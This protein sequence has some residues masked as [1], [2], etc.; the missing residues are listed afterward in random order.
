MEG[1]LEKQKQALET[2]KR[3]ESDHLNLTRQLVAKEEFIS[4]SS[5]ANSKSF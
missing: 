1:A 3:A 2:V 5:I 4:I